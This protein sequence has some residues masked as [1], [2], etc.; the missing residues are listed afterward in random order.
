MATLAHKQQE[1]T[2]YEECLDKAKV[3]VALDYRG[4]TVS[5]ITTLRGE[6]HQND[7]KMVVV[8]N[9]VLHRAT[10]ARSLPPI[11]QFAVGPTA[12]VFGFGDEVAPVK[13]LKAFLKT[14]KIGEI[15]GGYIANDLLDAKGVNE[16]ADM[17]SLEVLRGK[18][19]GAINTPAA[20]LV[21]AIN[22]PAQSLVNV[23]GQYSKKLQ[24]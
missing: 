24:S 13:S 7:A 21:Q 12:I 14:A 3:A 2:K 6:L 5:Q 11:E 1:L 17:P 16:L 20:R 22:H 9:T 8:K 10:G 18:L 15:K 4:L 23:L 19:L